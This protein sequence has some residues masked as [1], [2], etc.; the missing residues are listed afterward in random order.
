MKGLVCTLWS[1]SSHFSGRLWESLVTCSAGA[2]CVQCYC[3]DGSGVEGG[4][5]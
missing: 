2:R 1:S 3:L 5:E 4:L